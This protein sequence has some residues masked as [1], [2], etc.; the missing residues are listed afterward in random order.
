LNVFRLGERHAGLCILD[1]AGH[2]V[3][4]AFLSVILSQL[5]ARGAGAAADGVAPPGEVAARLVRG[6]TLEASA[7]HTV[8]LLYGVLALDAGEFRFVSAGH[9]GPVYLAQGKPPVKLEVTGFP[10]GVGD[11]GYNEEVVSVKPGDRLALYSDGLLGVRNA[12]AEHFAARRLLAA[13]EE[14]RRLPLAD[15]LGGLVRAI[16]GGRANVPPQDDI[17]VLLVER[18]EETS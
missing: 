18:R 8:S 5:I 1:V 16:E 6:L 14:G 11:G 10:L 9:P 17:S 7:G 4:A 15:A 2:G 13:L 3:A 12:E